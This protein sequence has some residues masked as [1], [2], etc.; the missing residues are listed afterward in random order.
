M[1]DPDQTTPGTIEWP[2]SFEVTSPLVVEADVEV[3]GNPGDPCADY[4]IG[5]L[6]TVHTQWLHYYYWGQDSGHGS[7]IIKFTVPLPIRDG[8]DPGIMWYTG[9]AHETPAGCNVHVNPGMDDYPTIFRVDK[10]HHNTHTGHPNYLTGVRRGIGFVTT[11]VASGPDGV[12]PLRFF[13]WN[14]NMSVDLTPDYNHPNA[15]WPFV[16]KKNTVNVGKVH[17][18]A[19]PIVPIFAGPTPLYVPSLIADE[20]ERP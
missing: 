10:V 5:F 9:T 2:L 1:D 3:T 17:K 18:G 7:T 20:K 4:Q 15:A 13:Y 14:I 16:W 8:D 11:L 19:D 12:Q 6:Q